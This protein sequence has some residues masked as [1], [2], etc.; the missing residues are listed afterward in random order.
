MAHPALLIAGEAHALLAP[1]LE[2]LLD[3]GEVGHVLFED[4]G[5]RAH[6][7]RLVPVLV[8]GELVGLAR[9]GHGAL[10]GAQL[11]PDDVHEARVGGGART[12]AVDQRLGH[13]R[14]RGER[15]EQVIEDRVEDL[16]VGVAVEITLEHTGQVIAEALRGDGTGGAVLGDDDL[17]LAGP[18]GTERVVAVGHLLFADAPQVRALHPE[19]IV[20]P[21]DVGRVGPD[22]VL[23]VRVGAEVEDLG[24]RGDDVVRPR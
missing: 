18:L 19:R 4:R 23:A 21:G 10:V 9:L 24:M 11:E 8:E 14:P 5:Q 16:G 20:E 1:A 15:R 2:A 6:P 7:G 13:A 3:L 12:P 17:A 22:R